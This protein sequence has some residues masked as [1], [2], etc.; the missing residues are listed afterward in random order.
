MELTDREWKAFRIGDVFIYKRGQRQVAK[1]RVHGSIP[2]YSASDSNNGLTDMI[3]N[4]SFVETDGAI[5]CS[6][7]GDA[8]FVNGGFSASDEMTILKNAELNEYN[9]LFIAKM[10][11]QQKEKYS[12]GHKAFSKVL[13]RDHVMLPVTDA[14]DPDYDFMEKY[15]KERMLKKYVQYFAFQ[16]SRGVM[17]ML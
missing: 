8:Y 13:V 6:T 16:Q 1:D 9:G 11:S 5:V 12:F 17:S 7:F 10:I 14:G 2:Y 3:S 4:P 15:I